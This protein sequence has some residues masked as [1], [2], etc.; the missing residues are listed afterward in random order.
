MSRR[1]HPPDQDPGY[2]HDWP[3]W[4]RE[5]PH[6]LSRMFTALSRSCERLEAWHD[7]STFTGTLSDEEREQDRVLGEEVMQ[8]IRDQTTAISAAIKASGA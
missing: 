8:D 3:S 6:P 1:R 2:I 7:R 4:K 5:G